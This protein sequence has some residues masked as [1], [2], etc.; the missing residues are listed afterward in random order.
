MQITALALLAMMN[1]QT[2][3]TDVEAATTM[4]PAAVVPEGASVMDSGSWI[5]RVGGEPEHELDSR[6]GPEGPLYRAGRVM[7]DTKLPV[8]YPAPTVPGAYEIKHYASVRRAEFTSG[9]GRGINGQNGFWP[10]FQHISRNDIAM[11]APVEM[12]VADDNNDGQPDQWT[13]S[14]LYHQ[15]SDGPTGNDGNVVIVDTEPMT[16]LSLGV[17]GRR[18]QNTWETLATELD[19]WIAE[20]PEWE[21]VGMPRVLGY[22]GPNVPG[23][24]QWWEIQIPVERTAIDSGT[25]MTTSD[26]PVYRE[27]EAEG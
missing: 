21:R 25:S 8:G 15:I 2:T 3:Q 9:S 22:N 4:Q 6:Q 7:T 17:Q 23:R 24:N 13:M 11:T 10:L 19:A 26:E 5:L 12:E 27:V 18:G 1:P 20:S 16:Y 14:F